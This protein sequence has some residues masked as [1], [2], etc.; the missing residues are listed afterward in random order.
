MPNNNRTCTLHDPKIQAFLERAYQKTKGERLRLGVPLILNALLGRKW[1]LE[2]YVQ[3]TKEM[4]IP[5]SRERGTFAYLLARSIN[6]RRIV[7]FGTGFGISTI[8]LAAAIKDNGGG[9]VIGS[10][11]EPTKVEQARRN[12]EEMGL[13]EYVE[14]R[15][16]D[17]RETLAD[18]GGNVD[19]L[20]VD[21]HKDF[22]I[23]IVK[24]LTPHLRPGAVVLGDNV[25]TGAPILKGLVPYV[26]FMKDLQNGFC[27]VTIPFKDGLEYSVRI[28][29]N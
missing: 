29:M 7:E 26:N 23:D 2:E 20:L 5:L 9:V 6:A 12:L 28:L 21:G 14:I 18:P 13:A 11:M 16:G 27:S 17:A 4:Y 25:T 3:R 19:M 10:E 1:S 8:Y 15:P 24:L 22:Y